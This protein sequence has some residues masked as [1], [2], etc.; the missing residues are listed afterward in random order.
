VRLAE[1]AQLQAGV[2]NRRSHGGIAQRLELHEA[3]VRVVRLDVDLG[4]GWQ[5][6]SVVPAGRSVI[7]PASAAGVMPSGTGSPRLPCP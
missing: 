3:L 6:S 2:A 7:S 4:C 5:A 1:V